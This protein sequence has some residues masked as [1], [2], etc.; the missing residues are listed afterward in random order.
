MPEQSVRLTLTREQ[1]A[2]VTD[3]VDHDDDAITLT[4]SINGQPIDVRV[5]AAPDTAPAPVP[6]VEGEPMRRTYLDLSTCVITEAESRIV[7]DAPV[8]TIEHEYGWWIH[9]P[10][11]EEELA[12]GADGWWSDLPNL[13]AVLRAAQERG[14]SW[15][16]LDQDGYDTIPGLPTFDW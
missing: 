12:E 9:V 3:V 14:A 13:R 2:D 5:S 10:M 1:L 16:N 4:G 6:T 15:V 11:D 7:S 8:R